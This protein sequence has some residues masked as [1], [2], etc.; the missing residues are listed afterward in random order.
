M[1]TNPHRRD[2]NQS[3]A[4]YQ[5]FNYPYVSPDDDAIESVAEGD[6][7]NLTPLET[8][9]VLWVMRVQ[10]PNEAVKSLMR[11]SFHF[12]ENVSRGREIRLR[13]AVS[14]AINKIRKKFP[15][16]A[17]YTTDYTLGLIHDEIEHL[18]AK[19]RRK[20][21]TDVG[22]VNQML[23]G[24]KSLHEEEVA[25]TQLLI[26]FLK[27]TKDLTNMGGPDASNVPTTASSDSNLSVNRVLA[28]AQRQIVGREDGD[29]G[30]PRNNSP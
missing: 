2:D 26:E 20:R 28:E 30:P 6:L 15:Y 13:P 21:Y 24:K 5:E 1:P 17:K 16:L 27:L 23:T 7:N 12:D 4:D 14:D 25:D 22:F 8:V 29:G 19:N 11:P 18:R 10:D 3:V 9:F